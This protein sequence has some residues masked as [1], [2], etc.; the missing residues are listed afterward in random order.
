MAS[1]CVA[2]PGSAKNEPANRSWIWEDVMTGRTERF[3][4]NHMS[5]PIL[6]LPDFFALAR[7]LGVADVEIRNDLEKMPILDGTSPA[8]VK[9]LASDAGVSII[10]INALQRFNAWSD[11]RAAEAEQLLDYAAA[12]GAAALVL[13]PLNDGTGR[14]NGER[15]ANLRVALKALMPMLEA[16]GLIG[17]V[18]CLGFEICSLRRKS[19]AVDAI[20]AVGGGNVFRLVHDTFHHHIAAEAAIFPGRTGL[21]HISGVTDGSVPLSDLRDSHRVLVD[22]ADRIGNIAQIRSLRAGGYAGPLSFEPFS[23][24]VHASRT[25][26]ADLAASM[27]F[28]TAAM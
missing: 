28:I 22:G 21:V 13:V 2:F 6:G 11:E 3:A 5:A 26:E 7:S 24:A 23:A 9:S 4:L 25:L 8:Q 15:Q 19:E 16:R 18:E 10:T 12:C 20:D 27:S 1:S 17:L 14:G